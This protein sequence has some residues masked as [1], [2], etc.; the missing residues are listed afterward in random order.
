MWP[1]LLLCC[2]R[3]HGE[4]A[5][6]CLVCTVARTLSG[7]APLRLDKCAALPLLS[8]ATCAGSGARCNAPFASQAAIMVSRVRASCFRLTSFL[9]RKRAPRAL[10]LAACGRISCASVGVSRLSLFRWFCLDTSRASC[11]PRAPNKVRKGRAAVIVPP[12]AFLR[13]FHRV[14]KNK[15]CAAHADKARGARFYG[16][17]CFLVLSEPPRAAK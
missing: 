11:A 8:G 4:L 12:R 9:Y 3:G 2:F 7:L 15:K 16:K 1:V 17:A 5:Q 6:P 10:F 14:R 13:R